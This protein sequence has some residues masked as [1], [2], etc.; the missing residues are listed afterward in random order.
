M[1]RDRCTHAKYISIS[2]AS[3][4]FDCPVSLLRNSQ[5]SSSPGVFGTT[6]PRRWCWP[7]RRSLACAL[8][9]QPKNKGIAIRLMRTRDG[10]VQPKANFIF[11]FAK[12]HELTS[13]T[14]GCP[15]ISA[16]YNGPP[17]DPETP[18][19]LSTRIQI[20]CPTLAIERPDTHDPDL[21]RACWRWSCRLSGAPRL[22]RLHGKT[23]R[24]VARQ[25]A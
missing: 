12:R 20:S 4:F 19:L 15:E 3:G 8:Q 22:W 24:D 23:E 6:R 18:K 9:G 14:A 25:K 21:P 1:R 16:R 5:K 11:W 7:S 17:T 13:T 2:A 10:S